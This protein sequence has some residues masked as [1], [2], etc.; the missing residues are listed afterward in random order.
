MLPIVV[1]GE[2]VRSGIYAPHGHLIMVGTDING[3]KLH[4]NFLIDDRL[5]DADY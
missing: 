1:K 4:I 2:D 5:I 3:L